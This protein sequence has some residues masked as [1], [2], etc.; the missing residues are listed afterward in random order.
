MA[1]TGQR[2]GVVVDGG[3]RARARIVLQPV[4][5]LIVRCSTSA[6]GQRDA[7]IFALL[8]PRLRGAGDTRDVR[9][10]SAVRIIILFARPYIFI[11][12]GGE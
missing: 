5:A 3:G 11:V 10:R 1:N 8:P 12:P 6:A 9:F 2:G 7:R 4:T